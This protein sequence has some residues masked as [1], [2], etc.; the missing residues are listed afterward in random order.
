M[1][2]H[3]RGIL[4]DSYTISPEAAEVE[5]VLNNVLNKRYNQAERLLDLSKLGDDPDLLNTGLIDNKNRIS[6]IFAAL[7][8]VCDKAF[9][10]MGRKDEAIVSISLADNDIP[11]VGVVVSLADTFP[12]IKNLDLSGN[13]L[14]N[15]HSLEKW[16]FGFRQLEYLQ[17]DGNPIENETDFMAT[18]MSRYPKLRSLGTNQQ[19]R[20]TQHSALSNQHGIQLRISPHSFRDEA[21]I[22]KNFLLRFFPRYDTDR[23]GVLKD[24]YD[25][26]STFS[27][28]VNT[29]APRGQIGIAL[30]A[31]FTDYI[32][33]SRNLKK[34]KSTQPR[35]DRLYK[36]RENIDPVW[37]SLAATR[38]PDMIQESD[39]WCLECH[40]LPGV[41]DTAARGGVNG[42]IIVVHGE[43]EDLSSRRILSFDRTFVLGPGQGI[44]GVR[45]VSDVLVLRP[46]GGYEIFKPTT[47]ES[48]P[49]SISKPQNVLQNSTGAVFG[50]SQLPDPSHLVYDPLAAQSALQRIMQ[51]HTPE[52]LALPENFGLRTSDKT[53]EQLAKET[54]I[55]QLTTRT[56]MTIQYSDLCLTQNGWS[57]EQAEKDFEAVKGT[58]P[59][60]AFLPFRLS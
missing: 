57:L 18:M 17:L 7:M 42:L 11:N 12:N 3:Q 21:D 54:M 37:N 46:Y 60:A 28:S 45:V 29:E 5:G 6:K 43:F 14:R 2:I 58:L 26:T 32:A 13:R 35:M 24:S 52:S 8:S 53:E 4:S 51:S 30:P 20:A 25:A 16:K 33:Y 44:G 34:L 9:D 59:A 36:G 56:Q 55:M 10:S 22:A 40:S 27:L 38:H 49:Q 1:E 48:T 41:P 15:A 47:I 50:N 31:P 23:S 39:K 19:S